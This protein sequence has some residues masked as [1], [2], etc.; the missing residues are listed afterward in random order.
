MV[1]KAHAPDPETGRGQA[2]RV[3][4]REQPRNEATAYKWKRLGKSHRAAAVTTAH[5][6][7]YQTTT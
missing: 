1:M 3:R 4:C 5:P 2:D 7:E 6:V